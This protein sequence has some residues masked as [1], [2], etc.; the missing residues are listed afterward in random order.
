M[1]EQEKP[2]HENPKSQN[3]EP[4]LFQL[5]KT[6]LAMPPALRSHVTPIALAIATVALLVYGLHERSVAAHYSAQ[7]TDAAAQTK[8]L[9]AQVGA[10]TAKLDSLASASASA[11]PQPPAQVS[12][13][14][15]PSRRSVAPLHPA[16]NR[17]KPDPRWKNDPKY[18]EMNAKLRR[19][20]L[21]TLL[22]QRVD[23]EFRRQ[24]RVANGPG[25]MACTP[26]PLGPSSAARY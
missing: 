4:R 9:R 11:Q 15:A 19:E 26:I 24:R 3:H 2:D 18:T 7:T 22:H 12:A 16:G 10:L 6:H 8:E 25:L 17:Q 20:Y 23:R 21:H 1:L 14:V 5:T 13:T